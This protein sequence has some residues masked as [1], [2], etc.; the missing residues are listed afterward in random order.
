M[1]EETKKMTLKTFHA[2][3]VTIDVL[4]AASE[5]LSAA[6][7]GKNAYSEAKII[8]E[9]IRMFAGSFALANAPWLLDKYV[10]QLNGGDVAKVKGKKAQADVKRL[11]GE[12]RAMLRAYGL[13]E[14]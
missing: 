2:D 5:L 4:K 1:A 11:T 6:S 8:R 7:G 10:E 9:L 13:P 3:D 12:L 14:E